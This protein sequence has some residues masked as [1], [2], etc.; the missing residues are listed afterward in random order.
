MTIQPPLEQ[1]CGCGGALPLELQLA[2]LCRSQCKVKKSGGALPL[3]MC[4][5]GLCRWQ[6]TVK[7]YILH[8]RDLHVHALNL[9]LFL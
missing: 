6:C 4:L 5:A 7:P 9:K 2:G 3:V 8:F 1:H